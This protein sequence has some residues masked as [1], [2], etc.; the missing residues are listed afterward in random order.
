MTAPTN[1]TPDVT[2]EARAVLTAPATVGGI[3]PVH[4]RV[5]PN[6][7][8]L[9]VLRW[10]VSWLLDR[11]SDLSTSK[12]MAFLILAAFW[13]SHPMP[14]GVVGL[15]LAASFGYSAWKD[16]VSRG[17]WTAASTDAVNLAVKS[18]HTIAETIERKYTDDGVP[19]YSLPPKPDATTPSGDA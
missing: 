7:R 5:L 3:N 8:V 16:Y 12:V 6:S 4:A 9:R 19:K 13:R 15:L 11:N 2:S 14:V 1:G 17:S 10:P 18:E